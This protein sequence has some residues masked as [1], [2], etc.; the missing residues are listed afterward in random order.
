VGAVRVGLFLVLL[1][2]ICTAASLL[3][4]EIPAMIAVFILLG[5]A[6]LAC[7]VPVLAWSSFD[8]GPAMGMMAGYY[9]TPDMLFYR[10]VPPTGAGGYLGLLLGYTLGWALLYLLFGWLVFRHMDM[11]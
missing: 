2:A 3:L 10:V 7:C 4:S 11:P 1:N 5:V 9:L 8:R 6:L